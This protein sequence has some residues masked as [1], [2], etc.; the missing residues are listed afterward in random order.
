VGVCQSGSRVEGWCTGFE[1]YSYARRTDFRGWGVGV[2]IC[3]E[4]AHSSVE[5]A[6]LPVRV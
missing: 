3:L 5:C 1:D 2:G 6:Q 4:V